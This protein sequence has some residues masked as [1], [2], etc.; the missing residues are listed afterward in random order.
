MRFNTHDR[1]PKIKPKKFIIILLSVSIGLIIAPS[2][3]CAIVCSFYANSIMPAVI[4]LLPVLVL[5][6]LTAITLKD[7]DKSYVEINDNVI[8]VVDYYF[9]LKKEKTFL[10]QNIASAKIGVGRYM[11]CSYII[12]RDNCGK[13]MFNII[14]V[15]E[16]KQYFEKYLN[17]R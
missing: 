9:G 15:P 3:F 1:T 12:F 8:T 14:C 4:I 16:T 2:L 13:Y 17:R 11:G 5:S 10:M 7:R 6:L